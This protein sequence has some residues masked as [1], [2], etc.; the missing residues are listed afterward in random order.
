MSPIAATP[1]N[2]PETAFPSGPGIAS[3]INPEQQVK[4]ID[5]APKA[6]KRRAA[7]RSFSS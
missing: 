4:G 3:A 7:L 1:K 5:N 6:P 2:P